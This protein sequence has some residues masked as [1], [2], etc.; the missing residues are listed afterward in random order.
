MDLI[1]AEAVVVDLKTIDHLAPVHDVALLRDGIH[2]RV[3]GWK[4]SKLLQAP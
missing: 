4:S 3:L 1:V 2:R